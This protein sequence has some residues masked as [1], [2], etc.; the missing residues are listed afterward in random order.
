[1]NRALSPK[2]IFPSKIVANGTP[3]ALELSSSRSRV[4]EYSRDSLHPKHPQRAKAMRPQQGICSKD[5][6]MDVSNG[7]EDN[8]QLPGSTTRRRHSLSRLPNSNAREYSPMQ[9]LARRI[10]RTGSELDL[11]P[12]LLEELGRKIELGEASCMVRNLEMELSMMQFELY[13]L[14]QKQMESS[15]AHLQKEKKWLE[16]TRTKDRKQKGDLDDKI[17]HLEIELVKAKS[18]IGKRNRDS[19]SSQDSSQNVAAGKMDI[20]QEL[21]TLQESLG[22]HKK[23]IKALEEKQ[24]EMVQQLKS[25][26]E[27]Q[28]M[29]LGET[30]EAIQRATNAQQFSQAL[31]EERGRLQAAYNSIRLEKVA[32]HQQVQHL[33]MELE[34]AQ[35]KQEGFSDQVSAL[36]SE[37]ASA[38]TQVNHQDKEKVLMKE[39]LES[40]RQVNK[41]LSSEVAE[42]RRRL[43]A[44]LEKLHHLEAEKKILDNRIQALENERTQLLEE[45][46][47]RPPP[48]QADGTNQEEDVKPLQETC[49][50]LR[51]SQALLQREKDLLQ[52][53]CQELG[54]ALQAKREEVANQLAEQQQVSQYWRDQWEQ[55]TAALKTKEELEEMHVQSQTLPTQVET[56]LLLQIQLDACKQELELERNRSQALQHQIQ[57]LQSG[58][59]NNAVPEKEP[60]L[61]KVDTELVQ[62]ELQKV[63][64]MLK[65]C[66]TELQGQQQELESTRNQYTECILEKERLEQLVTSLEEQLAEKEQALRH[67]RQAKDADKMDLEIKV[68]SSQRKLAEME[69]VKRNASSKP[70]E[71][72]KKGCMTKE[73]GKPRVMCP[74][75]CAALSQLNQFIQN[76]MEKRSGEQEEESAL[77]YLC[78]VRDFLKGS[79]I[80]ISTPVRFLL[81]D[82][83]CDSDAKVIRSPQG[84][85]E[86]L[87][88]QHQLVTEQ[89]KGLFKQK[90]QQQQQAGYRKHPGRPKEESLVAPLKSQGLLAISEPV[91]LPEGGQPEFLDIP[92]IAGEAQSLHKQLKEKTETISAMA[93]EIQALKQKNEAL[94]KAK[95][96]FQQQIQEIRRLSK[97][98]PE[99]SS[100]E[101]LVPRLSMSLGQD[102]Q[103]AQGSD[104]SVHSPQSDEIA[105]S[106]RSRENL[107]S[108][109]QGTELHPS[110]EDKQSCIFSLQS[111]LEVSDSAVPSIKLSLGPTASLQESQSH[112]ESEG[113]LLS[114]HSSALLSPRPYGPRRPWAPFKFKGSPEPSEN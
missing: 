5:S 45:G 95:M 3:G 54:A 13:S 22:G 62:E 83:S 58:I 11:R 4:R 16:M 8:G 81:Q 60:T 7:I 65:T 87:K 15:F 43:E 56:P 35:K 106:F 64:D 90:Q 103:S 40:T 99:R 63:W 76:Y 49:A 53:C 24:D 51:E 75:C 26:K 105:F 52:A 79:E 18:C 25:A 19:P 91:R 113:A 47:G 85:Q 110:S 9:P 112:T 107:P 77:A 84:D 21:I 70:P 32:L 38:K 28:Q 59:Q 66:D 33:T 114:P 36:Y 98:Q 30:A 104:S 68:S 42:S 72:Q 67:L 88:Q 57:L 1:M 29:A 82:R 61:K 12:S 27:G 111:H 80:L 50:D 78:Q 71:M 39:E 73:D 102:L 41:E 69:D 23:H 6:I 17:F 14:K 97:Q 89:L 96:R 2:V 74:R 108:A 86:S 94:M 10:W 48:G 37:L 55:V 101:L 20:G 34:G 93:S 44:S 92:G 31:K 46:E 109:M 100:T